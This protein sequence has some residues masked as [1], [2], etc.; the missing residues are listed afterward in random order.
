MN[1]WK[2]LEVRCPIIRK[3][4]CSVI[5]KTKGE[6]CPAEDFVDIIDT[7]SITGLIV[8]NCQRKSLVSAAKGVRSI[9]NTAVPLC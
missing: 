1:V 6:R 5:L 7:K 8:H 4:K 9:A 3:D 2:K